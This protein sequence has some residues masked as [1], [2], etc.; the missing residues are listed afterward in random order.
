MRGKSHRCRFEFFRGKVTYKCKKEIHCAHLRGFPSIG[1]LS[2]DD[3]SFR[4]W[5]FLSLIRLSIICSSWWRYCISLFMNISVK[6][7]LNFVILSFVI[8]CLGCCY[9]FFA[10]IHFK[11]NSSLQVWPANVSSHF[12]VIL[13]FPF[14]LIAVLTF[15]DVWSGSRRARS[16]ERR[17]RIWLTLHFIPRILIQAS[18][19]EHFFFT[20][21]SFA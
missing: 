1:I 6:Y 3:G 8:N 9:G 19:V 11:A 12:V 2:S 15:R 5:F 16:P 18:Q 20:L 4:V 10:L 17:G 7:Q 14:A 21:K 13:P